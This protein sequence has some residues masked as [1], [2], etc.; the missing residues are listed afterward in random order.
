MANGSPK[1]YGQVVNASVVGLTTGGF[2]EL[3]F[4]FWDPNQPTETD[5][6]SACFVLHP[7][8]CRELVQQ[9]ETHLENLGQ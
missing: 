4:R 8:Q 9:L 7:K 1:I 3:A 5:A 2:L 6:S